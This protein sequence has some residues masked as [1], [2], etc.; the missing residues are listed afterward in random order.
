VLLSLRK[1]P[2]LR[3][4]L[5]AALLCLVSGAPFP[6]S[7]GQSQDGLIAEAKAQVSAAGLPCSVADARRAWP[8]AASGGSGRHGG[9]GGGGTRSDPMD[10]GSGTRTR[11]IEVACTGALGFV[12]IEPPVAKASKAGV[13]VDPSGLAA[14]IGVSPPFLNCLEANEAH[15]LGVLPVR[16]E[17]KS[18]AD[19]RK[20]L[21][22][23]VTRTGV[24]CEV[25]AG[26]SLGHTE[27]NSFFEVACAR[28]PEEVAQH[29]EAAGYVLAA[30]RLLRTDHAVTAFSCFDAESNPRVRCELT[31]VA[32]PIAALRR[33]VSKA[34]AT[35]EPVAVR[36]VGAT[37]AGQVFEVACANRDDYV[38]LR[39]QKDEFDDLTSCSNPK[40][41][42]ECRMVTG[43]SVTPAVPKT[44]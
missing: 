40:I 29:H 19:Q 35:C 14:P 18:N 15:R 16:C 30:D 38:A 36:L 28:S 23:L 13:G 1:L 11:F 32:D 5:S 43:P 10:G 27:D 4:L 21:Q 24:V 37:S 25:Q 20:D 7:A 44:E 2:G 33:Y 22:A 39:R 3:R 34:Q 6:A 26:R 17:L 42:G 31:H 9:R 41:A 12:F 8:E